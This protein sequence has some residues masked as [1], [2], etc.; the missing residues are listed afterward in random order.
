[1]KTPLA[2]DPLA[3]HLKQL[4]SGWMNQVN[5]ALD[6]DSYIDKSV[7]AAAGSEKNTRADVASRPLCLN[8]GLQSARRV[9]YNFRA[10]VRNA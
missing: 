6:M 7:L 8:F 2:G 1:P 5:W 10:E 9:R 3:E 4:P